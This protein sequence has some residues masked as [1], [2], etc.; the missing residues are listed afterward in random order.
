MRFCIVFFVSVSCALFGALGAFHAPN[1]GA[2]AELQLQGTLHSI[3]A[4]HFV[5]D[6]SSRLYSV[7]KDRINERISKYLET[8]PKERFTIRV[9]MQAIEDMKIRKKDP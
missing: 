2:G 5:I 3:S 7:R 9:P 1:A 4:N 6:S 8:N